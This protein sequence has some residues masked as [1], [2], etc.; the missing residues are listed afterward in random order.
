MSKG[1]W[2]QYNVVLKY[3]QDR[4][5]RTVT[6][7]QILNAT[8]VPRGSLT[9]ICR[10]IMDTHPELSRP[11]RGLY[12]WDDGQITAPE[13]PLDEA[14]PEKVRVLGKVSNG[15]LL[16]EDSSGAIYRAQRM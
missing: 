5:G 2:V 9:G 8:G 4:P 11:Q 16:I 15:D 12:R 14:L 6:V 13:M 10:R 7:Q 1:P 3:F